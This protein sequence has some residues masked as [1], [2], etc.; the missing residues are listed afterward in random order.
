MSINMVTMVSCFIS[1]ENEPERK[2]QPAS[3]S[4]CSHLTGSVISKQLV[5]A[6]CFCVFAFNSPALL[7]KT[8]LSAEPIKILTLCY[9]V[10]SGL[11]PE[12][13]EKDTNW[14]K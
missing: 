8:H 9:R 10:I 5:T 2:F 11:I 7:I 6:L 4:F 3:F 14:P 1:Y 13:E 12:S